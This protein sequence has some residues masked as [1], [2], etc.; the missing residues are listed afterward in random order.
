MLKEPKRKL[1]DGN[2]S[3]KNA[4]AFLQK[5]TMNCWKTLERG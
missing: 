5:M 4:K 3:A 2:G 1:K